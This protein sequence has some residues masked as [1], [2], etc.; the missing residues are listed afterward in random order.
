MSLPI[1]WR[2]TF[3]YVFLLALIL[4]AFGVFLLLRLQSDLVDGIDRS[5][6]SRAA[7][8]SLGFESGGEGELP[9]VPDAQLLNLGQGERGAQIIAA[10]GHVM[11]SSGDPVDNAPLLGG[12]SL[13]RVLGGGQVRVTRA[14]GADRESFRLLA[15]PVTRS[16]ATEALVVVTSLEDVA[17]SIHR[18]LILLL[19]AGP[20]AL[21]AASLGGWW[22]ARKALRPVARITEQ[23]SRIGIDRLDE[24]V[25]VPTVEDELAQLAR[26]LN[27]M[28]ER[29][30]RGVEDK[31]R[32]VA[33]AAHELRTPLAVM[34]SELEVS[35]RS[36]TL[37]PESREVLESAAEEVE[38][39]AR[40][41]DN[42]LLLARLD[43][44]RLPLL[45]THIDLR[46]LAAVVV[47]DLGPLAR[48][49]EVTVTVEG[50]RP[51]VHADH[52]RLRQVLVNV[53]DNAITHS[54]RGAEVRVSVWHNGVEAGV[55]VCD[56]GPGISP[57]S[58]N[59]VFDRFFREDPA[60]SRQGGGA[61]LGL[62][63]SREI[64]D[65]H[66]GRI[67]V[68]SRVGAGSTFSFALTMPSETSTT[69]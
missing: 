5:L 52:D 66:R 28:L 29:L 33:D 16:G 64:I 4:A 39:M 67:W 31:R 37:S 46:G 62:A 48:T 68:D 3:W 22:L 10:D 50:S 35:A 58:V 9:D 65:A 25:T 17:T 24:R 45:C 57:Q 56:S 34:R 42:L 13:S 12:S 1:R 15:V 14:L 61:G 44:G 55:S 43:E 11:D 20:A 41:V 26:T 60:R 69:K 51:T 38:G 21:A 6:D 59:R 36:R 54:P 40:M 8:I 19:L 49:H 7:Q 47:E 63:I 32:F 53:L 18:L 30:E 27:S 23:A 2:L